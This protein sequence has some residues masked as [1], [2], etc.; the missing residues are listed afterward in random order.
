MVSDF[1]EGGGVHT[2][3]KNLSIALSKKPDIEL[4]IV[5][6]NDVNTSKRKRILK[7]SKEFGFSLHLIKSLERTFWGK[8]MTWVFT[9]YIYYPLLIIKEILKLKP[10]IVHIHGV[11]HP[12]SPVVG[13]LLW[14]F[15]GEIPLILTAHGIYE[16]EIS[17]EKHRG[18]GIKRKVN[19]FI[20]DKVIACVPYIIAVSQSV[21]NLIAQKPHSKIYVIPNGINFQEIRNA[22]ICN[23]IGVKHPSIFFIGRLVGIKGVDILLKAVLI[24]KKKIP[25]VYVYI[26]GIGPLEKELKELAKKLNVEEN[27]DFLGFVSENEKWFYLKSSDLCVFPSRY[28]PFGIVLLEAMVCGKAII[29]SNVG[30]IPDIIDTGKTGL[31]FECDDIND[32]AKKIIYLLQN[33]MLRDKMGEAGKKKAKEFSWDNIAEKTAELYGV[34]LSKGC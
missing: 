8:I 33:K 22:K 2:H 17:H 30:G 9:D 20:A 16:I 13:V 14:I 23:H 3:V 6:V 18:T 25:D 5:S 4:H 11:T 31:L 19:N 28:E 34:V 27:V 12:P 10:D 29:A 21:K 1:K 24:I 7:L 32:L 26:A 15:F